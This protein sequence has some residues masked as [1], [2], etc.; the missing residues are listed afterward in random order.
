MLHTS[1]N[2]KDG[3][4]SIKNDILVK[5]N[6]IKNNYKTN[7]QSREYKLINCYNES[8]ETIKLTFEQKFEE[9]R[10]RRPNKRGRYFFEGNKTYKRP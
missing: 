3:F 8:L 6:E 1:N 10:K 7:L 2:G 9:K 4:Q 5:M